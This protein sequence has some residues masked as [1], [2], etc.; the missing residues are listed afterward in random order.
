MPTELPKPTFRPT[1][2]LPAQ[3]AAG[4]PEGKGAH[5]FLDDWRATEPRG[6]VA[7]PQRQVMAELFTSMLVLSASF[8][9]RPVPGDCNY[10]Y[11]VDGQWSL[12]LVA[13]HEWSAN[14]RAG[15]AGRCILQQDMTWTIEPSDRLSEGSPVASAIRRFFAAFVDMLDTDLTLE[16]ILPFCAGSLPYYQRLHASALSRSVR[17]AISGGDQ[18]ANSGRQWQLQLPSREND[19]LAYSG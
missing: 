4:N 2:G 15:F 19:L 11:W 14:R 13:P 7:K 12:S 17:E 3:K 8:K 9:Y 18:A 16:E 5:G 6:V 10:L 1:I